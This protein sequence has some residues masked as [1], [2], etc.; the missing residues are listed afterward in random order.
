M[1]RFSASWLSV[2]PSCPALLMQEESKL[3][4][5]AMTSHP[6]LSDTFSSPKG[7]CSASP[8]QPAP[9]AKKYCTVSVVGPVGTWQ[10]QTPPSSPHCHF[11]LCTKRCVLASLPLI[12][13]GL[14]T[15]FF[16]NGFGFVWVF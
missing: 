10:Q 7:S 8:P 1:G 14:G 13:L 15:V 2:V 16:I 11:A 3:L 6:P 5:T 9:W 4:C 12:A